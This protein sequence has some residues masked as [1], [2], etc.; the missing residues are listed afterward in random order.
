MPAER[1]DAAD[2]VVV[3]TCAF[4][5]EARQ[6][7]IDTVLALADAAPDGARVVVTGCM[8][9]RYG[10]ELAEALPEV[11][12]RG[13]GSATTP[14]SA[15]ACRSRS[16]PPSSDRR[17]ARRSTCC[18]LPRPAATAPWAYVKVAEGCDRNCGFCAIP[19]LPGP[20]A[21]A[22]DRRRLAEVD[23]LRRAEIV[24]VAQDLAAFG[25]D[26]GQGEQADR[27]AGARPS[28]SGST[29]SGCSTCIRPI[30]PTS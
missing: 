2:L 11:D 30:S 26:Q 9:E 25:R 17:G 1:P 28:P 14:S 5:E 3:N 4:I 19:T 22:A 20:A 24:L 10:D 7:S 23:A 6:E 29:G 8:A 13:S 16:A 12:A 15:S 18:N 21:L 27:A